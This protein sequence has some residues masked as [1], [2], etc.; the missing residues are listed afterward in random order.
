[1][2]ANYAKQ[3]GPNA[4]AR[5]FKIPPPIA[6]YYYRKSV[7]SPKLPNIGSIESPNDVVEEPVMP[8]LQHA[9]H[10]SG[11]PGFLRGRGR[12]R[13]KL[14][15]DELDANLLDYMVDIKKSQNLTAGRAMDLAKEYIK[16]HSPGLLIEEGGSVN[17]K[18]TWAIKLLVRV[19]EREQELS[20]NSNE[21]FNRKF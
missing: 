19:A 5:K 9:N 10:V 14:I 8:L 3:F 6:S 12:G 17:L 4:A 13:P 20:S 11:S 2:I 7:K 18:N 1:M 15:G 16:K 21:I